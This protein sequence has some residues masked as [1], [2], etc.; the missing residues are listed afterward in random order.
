MYL[1]GNYCLTVCVYGCLM[2][3][4]LCFTMIV[5]GMQVLNKNS[6]NLISTEILQ[7]EATTKSLNLNYFYFCFVEH[8]EGVFLLW[9]INS[10]YTYPTYIYRFFFFLFDYVR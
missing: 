8:A 2:Y 5:I 4:L 1:H 10:I 6:N 7:S 9:F 3:I